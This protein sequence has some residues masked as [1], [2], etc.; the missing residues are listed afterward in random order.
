MPASGPYVSPKDVLTRKNQPSAECDE[1]T[2]AARRSL[3]PN[4]SHDHCGWCRR[5]DHRNSNAIA[6]IMSSER[7]RP[8]HDRPDVGDRVVLE[9]FADG[10]AEREA[11]ER[12]DDEHADRDREDECAGVLLRPTAGPLSMPYRRLSARST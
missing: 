9:P 2:R 8:P 3:A 7:E 4:A 1:H 5:G 11:R 12:E 10:T 6:P